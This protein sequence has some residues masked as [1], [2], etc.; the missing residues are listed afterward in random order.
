VESFEGHPDQHQTPFG[1]TDSLQL[2]SHQ[3]PFGGTD[4][5]TSIRPLELSDLT[6]GGVAVYG[7][8]ALHQDLQLQA[9]PQALRLQTPQYLTT[10][11]SRIDMAEHMAWSRWRVAF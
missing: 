8:G 1:G 6:S 11:P 5:P 9:L 4:S 2:T 7:W 3:T 10:R